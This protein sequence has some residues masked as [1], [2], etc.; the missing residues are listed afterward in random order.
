MADANRRR[1]DSGSVQKARRAVYFGAAS[2]LPWD[3][4]QDED[5]MR[6][7]KQDIWG[8][9]TREGARILPRANERSRDGTRIAGDI[10][11]DQQAERTCARRTKAEKQGTLC[12]KTQGLK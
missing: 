9:V 8:T 4:C 5:Q 11:V 6:R 1:P 10:W 2:R 7:C 12:N 3:A